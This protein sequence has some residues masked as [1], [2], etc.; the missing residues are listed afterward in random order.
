MTTYATDT[1]DGDGSKVEFELTFDYIERDH[2][3]VSRVITA[4]KKATVLT[5]IKTGDPG[6]DEYIWET[7]KKVKVGKAPSTD[8]QLVIGQNQNQQSDEHI[9]QRPSPQLPKCDQGLVATWTGQRHP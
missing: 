2:V 7:D 8:E 6:D 5:V 1:F 9:Q 3:E 4:T